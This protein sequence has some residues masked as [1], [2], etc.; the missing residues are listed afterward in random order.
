[1][2]S[3][4]VNIRC[5]VC[6]VSS[7]LELEDSFLSSI[8]S[9]VAQIEIPKDHICKHHFLAFVDQNGAIRGYSQIHLTVEKLLE[10]RA[11]TQKGPTIQSLAISLTGLA[12]VMGQENL[13]KVLHNLFLGRRILVIDED[14]RFYTQLRAFLVTALPQGVLGADAIIPLTRVRTIRD[15]DLIGKE[16]LVYD[17]LSSAITE[18][19]STGEPQQYISSL[20]RRMMKVKDQTAQQLILTNEAR[21]LMEMASFLQ[22]WSTTEEITNPKD[23]RDKLSSQFKTKVER[24][25]FTFIAQMAQHRYGLTLPSKGVDTLLDEF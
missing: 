21:K 11:P 18:D 22:D 16:D 1:M 23:L 24:D 9:G 6:E 25:L 10:D 19:P 5:P 3:T 2:N 15:P 20:M 8:E 17:R 13:M 7:D 12:D 14:E 4:K